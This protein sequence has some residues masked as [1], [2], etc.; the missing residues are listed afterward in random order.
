MRAGLVKEAILSF[1]FESFGVKESDHEHLDRMDN[2]IETVWWES[3]EMIQER[4]GKVH[5]PDVGEI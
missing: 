2:L 4:T 5:C 1:A 3:T